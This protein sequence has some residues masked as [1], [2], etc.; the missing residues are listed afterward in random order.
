MCSRFRVCA[1]ILCS[2]VLQ[3]LYECSYVCLFLLLHLY[4]R[5]YVR[6]S[7]LQ[8]LYVRSYVLPQRSTTPLYPTPRTQSSLTW[9][10]QSWLAFRP[11][12]Q[13]RLA[14]WPSPQS[15]L[16]SGLQPFDHHNPISS[17]LQV[18]LYHH[19]ILPVYKI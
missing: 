4:V 13:S 6:S 11:S 5:S 18:F 10:A 9:V 15:K 19:Y 1:C 17:Q 7:V 2:Y 16:A 14:F 3:N 12:P 8:N